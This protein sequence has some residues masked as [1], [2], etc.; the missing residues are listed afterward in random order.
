VAEGP[1]RPLIRSKQRIEAMLMDGSEPY[2]LPVIALGKTFTWDVDTDTYELSD[3]PREGAP[4]NGVRFVL[5]QLDEGTGMPVE[6][7]AEVG[8][9][10]L[11]QTGTA[12]TSSATVQVVTSGGTTVMQYT[13]TV[14]GTEQAP[15]F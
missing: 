15:A 6:P 4:G 1:T 9:V 2:A 8:Y 3:P 14:G 13:A 11:T 10:Q 12:Q 5:Y 7:L